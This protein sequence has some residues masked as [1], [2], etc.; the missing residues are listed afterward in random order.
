[1]K[2]RG[3]FLIM[4]GMLAAVLTAAAMGPRFDRVVCPATGYA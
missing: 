1:M 2:R 4:L 3:L